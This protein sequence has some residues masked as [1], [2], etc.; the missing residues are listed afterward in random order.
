MSPSHSDLRAL[1]DLL[2]DDHAE[3]VEVARLKLVEQAA[4]ALPLLKEAVRSHADPKVRVEAQGVLERIRLADVGSQWKQTAHRPD[5]KLDLEES[6]FLLAKVS[7]PEVD[8]PAY[9]KR[10]DD[11]AQRVLPLLK[12]DQSLKQKLASIN[13]VL[14][15]DE[16][17]R[18]NEE[19][20]F[21]PQNSYLNRVLDRKLGI[22]I[23]LSILYLLVAKRLKLP[24]QGV[25]LPGH[26]MVKLKDARGEVY[27]DPFQAGCFL[28]RPECVLSLVEAGYPYQPEFLDGV[29]PR[30]ILARMLRNLILIYVDR[31]EQT[32]ERTLT[33]FLDELYPS[34]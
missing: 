25:G 15:R 18:G 5:E 11:L 12:D 2:A 8:A 4:E 1:I 31:H 26:F 20:Y 6:I 9:Q 32:L 23:S 22:P 7:Y 27:V 16:K 14:F 29:G 19:D 13:R 10:L 30:E 24:V 28:T 33:R 21:D 17:F 34:S 3:I